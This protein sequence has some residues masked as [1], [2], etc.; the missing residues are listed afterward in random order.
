MKEVKSKIKEAY[1]LAEDKLQFV[2]DLRKWIHED[3]SQ[4]KICPK[5]Q[6]YPKPN[7]LS[8]QTSIKRKTR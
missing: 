4:I 6:I 2:Y 8:H 1:D 3:L 7:I 5:P